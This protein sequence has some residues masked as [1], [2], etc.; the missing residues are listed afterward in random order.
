MILEL[1]AIALNSSDRLIFKI[2]EKKRY[3]VLFN[4][5]KQSATTA[6]T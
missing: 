5:W 3:F 2:E 6:N 4:L 1:G